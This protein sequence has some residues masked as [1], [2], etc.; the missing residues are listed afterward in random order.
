[1]EQVGILAE[2]IATNYQASRE[3]KITRTFASAKEAASAKVKGRGRGRGGNANVGNNNNN[4]Q[5]R[6]QHIH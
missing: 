4:Y 3:G 5:G 6:G 2:D 1:M